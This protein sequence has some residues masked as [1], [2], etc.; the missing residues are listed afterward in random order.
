[1]YLENWSTI[2]MMALYP[3]DSGSGPMRSTDMCSQGV[4]GIALG[5]SGAWI[6]PLRILVPWHRIQPSVYFR[7][8]ELDVGPPI[9]LSDQFLGFIASWCPAAMES[10]MS[11]DDVFM[12]SLV[13]WDV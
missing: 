2:T 3:D 9:V 6:F 5:H 8:S 12:K 11:S 1:M 10:M 4:L 7:T 13:L